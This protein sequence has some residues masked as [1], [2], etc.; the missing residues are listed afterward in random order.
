MPGHS[1][2]LESLDEDGRK[3]LE[4]KLLD[5]QSGT[6]FICGKELDLILHEGQLDIDHIIPRA[7]HGPDEENNLALTH[8]SCNRSK[9]AADLRVARRMAEFEELHET[10][11]GRG[12]RGAHLGHVLTKYGG[13][14]YPLRLKNTI[15]TVEFVLGPLD[16]KKIVNAPL[17]KDSL[18][19]MEYFFAVLPL[20]FLHHDDRINPRSI[21]SNIRG[22]IE[23]FMQKRP[24]LHIALAWWEPNANG[25]GEVK[26]F[27]G[28][29][30][31]AAQILL[32]VRE[33]PV[34]VFVKPDT[35][36]LLQANTNAGEKLRQ[37]AFDASV[38]RQLGSKLYEE[39]VREY[40]KLKGLSVNDVGF[41]EQD[42]IKFF[43]GEHREMTKYILDAIRV[44]IT[45]NPDNRLMEFV[46]WSGKAAEQPLAYSTIE[47]T[48]FSE[49]L[50]MQAIDTP[51]NKG[52]EEGENPRFLE[53]EQMIK[54][55]SLFAEIFFVKQW[56]PEKGGYRLESELQKGEN[57]P[58][59][60]LRAW[61]VGREEILAN[62]LKYVR[63]V[64]ENYYAYTGK[65]HKKD[66]LL[67]QRIPDDCWKRVECALRKISALPCWIDK[68]LS[69]TVFGA[70]QRRDFWATIFETGIS[71]QDVRVL[72]K[73]LDLQTL[74]QD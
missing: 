17:Y 11:K 22:L 19:E 25:S 44:F 10:A 64:I 33:L 58:E 12:D 29:H 71:P 32:G 2:L 21:G 54:L 18:S 60:H 42:L 50:H 34:R 57:I 51:I 59:G 27:D 45:R 39:R 61:R 38:L 49:F 20:E 62:I 56:D 9:G 7:N 74:I 6:C 68:E 47:K 36:I 5:R 28:Q 35:N 13:A 23:E 30:K 4:R 65:I 41:S 55:M 15:G 48:F 43:R 24:Q 3:A 31:A 1:E 72:A 63:L 16:D 37:V 73:P 69:R 53:R 40:Q 46:E 52:V 14:R 66:R 8:L 70:K 67:H 26:V